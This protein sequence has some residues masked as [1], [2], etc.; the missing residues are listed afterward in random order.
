MA[1]AYEVTVHQSFA[2]GQ[3]ARTQAEGSGGSIPYDCERQPPESP[4]RLE[5][6]QKIFPWTKLW[7][8]MQTALTP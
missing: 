5:P 2:S 7:N 6:A 1:S 4:L 3:L 8:Y